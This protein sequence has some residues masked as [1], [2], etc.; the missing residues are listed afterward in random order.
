MKIKSY[1]A[2]TVEGAMATARQ[3]L[4]SDA[5]L[6]NSRKTSIETRHLGEYEV[7][8]ATGAPGAEA[9]AAAL[10]PPAESNSFSAHSSAPQPFGERLATESLRVGVATDCWLGGG[11]L[12]TLVTC[13]QSSALN[14]TAT[15]ASHS[16][17]G[18]SF[19]AF[20]SARPEPASCSRT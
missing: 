14:A 4:G 18:C 6:V 17:A 2:R 9:A 5:M 1:F 3:E 12:G 13:L 11:R 7:V 15:S 8:F 20:F 10:A 16:N 19:V